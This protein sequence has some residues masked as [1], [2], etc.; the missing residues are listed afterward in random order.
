M[1][2]WFY[3]KDAAACAAMLPEDSLFVMPE[4]M[5]HFLS[6]E[7]ATA[8][9]QERLGD[10]SSRKY[11]EISTMKSNPC[12]EDAV[13]VSYEA[14]LIP[15]DAGESAGIRCSMIIRGREDDARI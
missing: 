7:G 9:I 12:G 10:T 15:A 6:R 3:E 2:N 14:G 11:V 13:A 4:G 5:Q 1:N 8:W